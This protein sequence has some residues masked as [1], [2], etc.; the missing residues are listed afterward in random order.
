MILCHIPISEVSRITEDD[1]KYIKTFIQ[2]VNTLQ[3]YEPGVLEIIEEETKNVLCRKQKQLKRQPG[4]YKAEYRY[5]LVK[6]G[7]LSSEYKDDEKILD[8]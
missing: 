5:T 4:L 6:A 7:K 8:Y 2:S 3:T 1:V